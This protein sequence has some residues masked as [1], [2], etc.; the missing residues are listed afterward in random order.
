MVDKSSLSDV[1]TIKSRIVDEAL[2]CTV[3]GLDD[4]QWAELS[5]KVTT[6]P[7]RTCVT[8]GG[9]DEYD[10][11]D[12]AEVF[13]GQ[14]MINVE[15][16]R[17]YY[18]DGGE[19]KAV[20][21]EVEG[22]GTIIDRLWDFIAESVS[23]VELKHGY[24]TLRSGVELMLRGNFYIDVKKGSFSPDPKVVLE[25]LAKFRYNDEDT[26]SLEEADF[27]AEYGYEV[28]GKRDVGA[29]TYLAGYNG[30]TLMRSAWYA[31]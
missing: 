19:P 2:M 25:R 31:S 17:I 18:T 14:V 22:E 8:R 24:V 12:P 11:Y 15:G 30:D 26:F 10:D 7:I 21:N 3:Y 27:L 4:T 23:C 5:D 20:S 13:S 9:D 29:P 28:E 16:D 6:A 1:D